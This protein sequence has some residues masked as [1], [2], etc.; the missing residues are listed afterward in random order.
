MFG[1]RKDDKP[2]PF[3]PDFDASDMVKLAPKNVEK[4]SRK[5]RV[6]RQREREE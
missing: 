3:V 5:E 4:V 1:K 6:K 2:V